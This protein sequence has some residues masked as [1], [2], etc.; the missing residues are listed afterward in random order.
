M[1]SIISDSSTMNL[2]SIALRCPNSV[3]TSLLLNHFIKNLDGVNFEIWLY[4]KA[5]APWLLLFLYQFTVI[6]W[7]S[8]TLLYTVHIQTKEQRKFTRTHPRFPKP[9]QVYRKRH[10][11]VPTS[12]RVYRRPV[13]MS[14]QTATKPANSGSP[15]STHQANSGFNFYGNPCFGATQNQFTIDARNSFPDGIAENGKSSPTP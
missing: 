10:S 5:S 15:N 14:S 6:I 3:F 12:S 1:Y 7:I 11:N 13:L 8:A 2:S 4:K 9:S